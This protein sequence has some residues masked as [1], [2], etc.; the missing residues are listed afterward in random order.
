MEW[1]RPTKPGKKKEIL[2]QTVKKSEEMGCAALLPS[3]AEK[4]PRL[5]KVELI[6]GAPPKNRI[7]DEAYPKEQVRFEL[8]GE[9]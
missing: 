6:E 2:P 8:N 9:S 4:D 7:V 5:C 3:T 1:F